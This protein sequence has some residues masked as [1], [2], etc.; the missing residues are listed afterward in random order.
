MT[1]PRGAKH[2][3][4]ALAALPWPGPGRLSGPSADHYMTITCRLHGKLARR[5]GEGRAP[6]PANGRR[7]IQPAGQRRRAAV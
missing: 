6:T 4:R 5:A 3:W 1:S 7:E 2:T